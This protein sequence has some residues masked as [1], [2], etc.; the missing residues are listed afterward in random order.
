MEELIRE[1]NAL[2]EA[3]VFLGRRCYGLSGDVKRK[4]AG[5]VQ[6]CTDTSEQTACRSCGEHWQKKYYREG[7]TVTAAEHQ[8]EYL[9]VSQAEQERAERE[10][11]K[12]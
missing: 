5:T 11:G 9:Q 6:F 12:K 2:G 8:P 1:L 7:K 3:V 4:Y 10:A